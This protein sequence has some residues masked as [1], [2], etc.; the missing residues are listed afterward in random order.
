MYPKEKMPFISYLKL[1]I[2]NEN[3]SNTDHGKPN[4][5]TL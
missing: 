3:L 5:L 4:D 2:K 1:D